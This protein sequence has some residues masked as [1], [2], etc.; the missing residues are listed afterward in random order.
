MPA[1]HLPRL[2][3]QTAALAEKFA[4]PEAFLHDINIL[5]EQYAD[6]VHRPGHAGEPP[7]LV[8]TYNV[9]QP[10]LRHLANEILPLASRD[11][12]QTLA[13][14]DLLWEEP[15]LET[16]LL[17]ISL[18]GRAPLSQIEEI[19]NRAQAWA[20]ASAEERLINTISKQGLERIRREQPDRLL[21]QIE[22][23]LDSQNSSLQ[24]L[25]LRGLLPLVEDPRFENLPA[26]L[27]LLPP[28]TRVAPLPVRPDVLDLLRCLARRSP[29]ETAYFLRQNLEAPDNPDTGLLIRQSLTAFPANIGENLRLALRQRK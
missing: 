29:R 15:F 26:I 2:R 12:R 4:H 11:A 6:R 10:M 24:R 20:A 27:D 28:F 5:F 18:L 14:C 22:R 9:P 21:A 17:A 25:G 8:Q 23:W 1:I 19:L 16:R 3:K 7:P 13:L